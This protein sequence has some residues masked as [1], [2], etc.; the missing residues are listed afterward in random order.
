MK[1]GLQKATVIV[2]VLICVAGAVFFLAGLLL[3]AVPVKAI[4]SG[5]FTLSAGLFLL[6]CS[7]GYL[8]FWRY[9]FSFIGVWIVGAALALHL[10]IY[11]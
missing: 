6:I 1:S 9:I 4:Y 10:T 11:V 2:C 8:R 5:Y 7:L 3:V